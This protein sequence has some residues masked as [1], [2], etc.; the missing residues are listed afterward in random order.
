MTLN[1][2]I[3]V[4]FLIA[5]FLGG[6][7][8]AAL[9]W[10]YVGPDHNYWVMGFRERWILLAFPFVGAF[11]SGFWAVYLLAPGFGAMRGAAV[12]LL[13][14]LTLSLVLALLGP[15]GFQSGFVDGIGGFVSVLLSYTLFG[16]IFFGWALLAIGALTGRLFK[17]AAEK[18]S[19]ESLQ[20]SA[21]GGG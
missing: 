2:R 6:V 17:S 14:F 5:G 20:S 19:N 9:L 11:L 13:A 16:F 12:S 15:A 1:K 18:H 3:F 21:D 7:G 4:Y 10:Q 8:G